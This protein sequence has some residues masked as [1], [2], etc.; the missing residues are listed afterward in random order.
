MMGVFCTVGRH[1]CSSLGRSSDGVDLVRFTNI[2][3]LEVPWVR[4]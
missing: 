3:C 4:C 2:A 1:A